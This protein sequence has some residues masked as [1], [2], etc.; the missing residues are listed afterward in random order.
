MGRHQ[1]GLTQCSCNEVLVVLMHD[2]LMA[3]QSIF[4]FLERLLRSQKN[5]L[6]QDFFGRACLLQ[7]LR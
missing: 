3:Y 7:G 1:S 4:Y 2:R 6:D 5:G